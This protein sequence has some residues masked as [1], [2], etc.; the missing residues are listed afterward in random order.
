MN[1]A[2]IHLILNHIPVLGT[3]FGMALLGWGIVRRNESVQRAALTTFVIIALV[4]IG[5]YLTG[6]PAEETV[7][8]LVDTASQ[9]IETHEAAALLALV[10]IE[11]L[12]ATALAALLWRRPVSFSVLTRSSL[13][14]ALVT[15]GL[16]AWTANLGGRIRHLE[17]RQ[18]TTP[19]GEQ[20]EHVEHG[21][22]R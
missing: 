22:G 8:H 6:E 10:G 14:L 5:V 13:V 18:A 12:G 16:M 20:G 21:E 15:A 2:H 19:A 11:L 7:E 4:A 3:L 9:A 17:L 1:W